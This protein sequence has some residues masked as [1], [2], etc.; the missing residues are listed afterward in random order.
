MI[1]WTD[2]TIRR[3][4]STLLEVNGFKF[5]RPKIMDAKRFIKYE[6]LAVWYADPLVRKALGNVHPTLLFNADE[7]SVNRKPYYTGK[8]AAKGKKSSLRLLFISEMVVML[9][10][11]LSYLMEVAYSL[12]SFFTWSLMNSFLLALSWKEW[13]VYLLLTVTWRRTLSEWS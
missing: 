7:T 8:V 6:T 1:H 11:S 10:C 3:H 4:L 5:F 9:H 2:E 12:F 13:S